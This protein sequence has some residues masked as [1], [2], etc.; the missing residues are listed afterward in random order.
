MFRKRSKINFYMIGGLYFFKKKLINN[1]LILY[2]FGLLLKLCRIANLY[3]KR[4]NEAY[5]ASSLI[6]TYWFVMFFSWWSFLFHCFLKFIWFFCAFA[7]MEI[8]V[9]HG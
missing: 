4:I 5:L 8:F 1:V 7:Y 9:N 3:K 6:T 2:V